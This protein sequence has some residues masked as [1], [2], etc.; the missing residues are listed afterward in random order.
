M[1]DFGSLI[2]AKQEEVVYDLEKF[3]GALDVKGTHT[4]PRPAQREAM[5]ALTERSGQKDSVLKVSTGAG[6]TTV[7]LLYL[8]GYMRVTGEPVVFLCPTSQ[9]IDQVLEEAARLG[10]PAKAYLGGETYPPQECARGDAVMVCTYEKLFNARSTFA[11]PKVN[12][13][14]H[15]IVLDDA[16]A[17]VENIRK[18]FTL[19]VT[20]EAYNRLIEVLAPCCSNYH[21]TK[22]MDVESGD[23]GALLEVPH[24]IWTDSYQEIQQILH[25][26]AAEQNF[27]FVWPYLSGI[28][29]LCRCVISGTKLEISPEVLPTEQVRAYAQAE[30][31]LFMS[32]TLADDSLLTRELGVSAAAASDPILPPSDRGLGERMILAPSLI[33]PELDR[34]YVMDLCADLSKTHNVVVLTSS[35]QLAEDWV[36]KGAT[37][38][39]DDNFA[40]GVRRLKNPGSGTRFAVFAQRFDGVDLPDDACRVLVID[41]TPYGAGLI[42]KVDSTMSVTPGGV[43]NRTIFRIEQGMGR[44]VRSHADFAVVLLAGQDLTTYVGRKDVLGAMTHDSRNQI[45]LCIELADMVR[46]SSGGKPDAA[47]RQVIGQCLNRDP[48]WKK[49]YN[50]KV[51]DVAKKNP[52]IAVATIELAEQ[53]RRA[54]VMASNNMSADA[55]PLLQKA[56]HTAKLTGDELGIHL[57]RL[58]RITYLSD[59]VEAMAIQQAARENNVTLAIPPSLPRKPAMPGAKTVAEKVCVWFGKFANPNAAVIEAQR[60]ANALDLNQKSKKVEAALMRL[61]E[62]LGAEASRPDEEFSDGPDGLWFWGPRALVIEAKNENLKTLHK[63]DSGQLHDSMQWSQTNYPVFAERFESLVVAKVTAVDHDANYPPQ[64]RV[65]TQA[66]CTALGV[67]LVQFMQKLAQL[68]PVFASPEFVLEEMYKFKLHPD[69]FFGTYTVSLS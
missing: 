20:G 52:E 11:N 58:S 67:A 69:Q 66:G 12:L 50:A 65:L 18:Q 63:K 68:G 4:E 19:T 16:H 49:Y 5:R 25:G 39:K 35:G 45:N 55:K 54:H 17:G 26:Y 1:I 41:G 40:E 30:H 22:W 44:P 53:E 47:I 6:K 13:V 27:I 31:R 24:W 33:D 61:G 38:F 60:I 8:Y 64:T 51:R 15:A 43:R 62:A 37:Y 2:G 7:G 56:I 9:L 29:P 10:I 36:A 23:P 59:V 46:K 42:D 48:G 32:A 14:P 28:L 3:Y 21:R 34:A 57:Q